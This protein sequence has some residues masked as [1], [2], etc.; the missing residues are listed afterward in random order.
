MPIEIDTV[1]VTV[2]KLA[3]ESRSR[4]YG[5]YRGTVTDN[6]DPDGLARIMA[7]VPSV[8]GDTEV[9]WALPAFP[10]AGD[11]HGLVTLPEAGSMVWIEFE[12]GNLNFPIWSGC[13][14]LAG[15]R[16]APDTT[17]ARV[18]VSKTGHELVLDD[19]D[20]KVRLK[21][22]GGATIEM[23]GSD[24]TLTIGLSKIVM[25]N[26]AI[27]INEGVLKIGPG[28]LSLAQGAMTLGVPPT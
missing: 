15:Q 3:V 22:S 5:K 8:M 14:F 21:H 19:D 12:A 20:A 10:F 23:T 16:P 2:E 24:I 1:E 9:G 11:G 13:F 6:D 17:G 27:T 26:S 7:Q 28:G 18:I 25:T 4:F